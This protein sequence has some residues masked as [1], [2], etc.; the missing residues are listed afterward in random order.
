[1]GEES[2]TRKTVKERRKRAVRR[3][4]GT[5]QESTRRL[6]L[7]PQACRESLT[8]RSTRLASME[9]LESDVPLE[10]DPGLL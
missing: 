5:C 7:L 10:R 3:I 9:T 8:L 6:A 4:Y 2:E 1:L